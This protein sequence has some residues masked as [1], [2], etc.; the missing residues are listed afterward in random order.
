MTLK[1][2]ISM[3]MSSDAIN[4]ALIHESW[5]DGRYIQCYYNNEN[6]QI[7]I[8]SK[9]NS[10]LEYTEEPFKRKAFS[11]IK[12]YGWHVISAEGLVNYITKNA[13]TIVKKDPTDSNKTEHMEAYLKSLSDTDIISLRNILMQEYINV[14][15]N[16]DDET[17][18]FENLMK[19]TIMDFEHEN[20]LEKNK[21][22]VRNVIKS[23]EEN[24]AV[25][26]SRSKFPELYKKYHK[27]GLS[28]EDL[29]W[30][31]N[32]ELKYNIFIKTDDLEDFDN[33]AAVNVV[34]KRIS[35]LLN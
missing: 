6:A 27:L 12:D 14:Y 18:F 23:F 28:E 24:L 19:D 13:Q 15:C 35:N 9:I 30:V 26:V 34:K 32:I 2:G 21:S 29:K 10:E 17:K 8:F 4:N 22:Y 16:T 11:D 25:M 33:I 20:K 31:H 7:R 1:E 3:L 5:T